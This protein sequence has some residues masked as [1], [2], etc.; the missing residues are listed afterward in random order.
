VMKSVENASEINAN[1]KKLI[2][3]KVKMT[4]VGQGR[5]S[6]VLVELPAW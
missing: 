5:P 4:Q 2:T 1:L 6:Y 3:A